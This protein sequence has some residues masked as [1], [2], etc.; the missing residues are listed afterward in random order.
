MSIKLYLGDK[1]DL[2]KPD[3]RMVVENVGSVILALGKEYAFHGFEIKKNDNGYILSAISSPHSN[4]SLVDLQLVK[5]S[6]PVRVHDVFV[7]LVEGG[8]KVSASILS[9]NIP[10]IL[11]ETE[12]IRVKK[13]RLWN[14][15]Q[16]S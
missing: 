8:L 1:L 15:F 14:L 2:V 16:K 10:V 6:N 7:G 11:T 13:R 9:S 12:V 4:I 5:D 3:D